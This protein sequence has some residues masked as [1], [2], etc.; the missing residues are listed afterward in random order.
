MSR[1]SL[2]SCCV[3]W[4]FSVKHLQV[5]YISFFVFVFVFSRTIEY[6]RNFNRQVDKPFPIP[7]TQGDAPVLLLNGGAF[8]EEGFGTSVVGDTDL[9]NRD[10]CWPIGVHIIHVGRGH[11]HVAE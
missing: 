10:F 3:L 5:F 8:V 1:T 7:F 2:L 4:L 9:A 11:N 6:F